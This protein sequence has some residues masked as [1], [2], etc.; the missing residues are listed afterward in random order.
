MGVNSKLL[1]KRK[2]RQ[3]LRDIRSTQKQEFMVN[4]PSMGIKETDHGEGR[5][6]VDMGTFIV[7][8]GDCF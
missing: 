7:I 8:C 3:T 4:N 2:L 5:M 1:V 6:E